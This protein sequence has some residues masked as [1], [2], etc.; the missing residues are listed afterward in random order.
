MKYL[1]FICLIPVVLFWGCNYPKD[2]NNTLEK[3]KHRTIR[4]GISESP[5]LCEY[6]IG[7]NEPT[8]VE[9]EL[10]KGYAQSI[11]AKIEWIKGS[12]EQIVDLI[13][14]YEVDVA[15]GGYSKNSA[16][17]THVG[18]TRPY[19]TEK[20]KVGAGAGSTIPKEIEEKEVVVKR[21]SQALVAVSKNKGIPVIKDSITMADGLVAGP[22]E[23][24]LKLGLSVSEYNL[25]KVEH[26]I[27]VPKGENGLLKD[28]ENYI[29]RKWEKKKI[30]ASL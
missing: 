29:I 20:I 17:K 15:I 12:Q 16:F 21:G 18:L 8:G 10:I 9:V 25:D 6:S 7:N 23:E 3:I 1:Q 30:K 4:V 14:E 11:D 5:Q 2:P 27:A 24:L 19:K 28:L 13:K 22:E 26:V